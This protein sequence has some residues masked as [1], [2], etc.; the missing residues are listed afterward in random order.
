MPRYI[1]YLGLVL[2]QEAVMALIVTSL[3]NIK[4]YQ[5]PS[6]WPDL[7]EAALSPII[8]SHI[9]ITGYLST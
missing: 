2:L 8:I 3:S 6:L 9:L 5:F 7:L 4:T 1:A